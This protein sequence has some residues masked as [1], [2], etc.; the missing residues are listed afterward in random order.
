M[1]AGAYVPT[2]F[3]LTGNRTFDSG[4]AIQTYRKA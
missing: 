2:S 4:A 3:T 1:F